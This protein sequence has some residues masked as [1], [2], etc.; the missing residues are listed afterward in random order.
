MESP[1][2]GRAID[3]EDSPVSSLFSLSDITLLMKTLLHL[4]D[5]MNSLPHLVF[6]SINI[7]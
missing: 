1:G 6:F 7:Q 4:S 2:M 3:L 5:L